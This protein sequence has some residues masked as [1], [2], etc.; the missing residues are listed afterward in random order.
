[1]AVKIVCGTHVGPGA[2]GAFNVTNSDLGGDTPDAVVM[3]CTHNTSD[4]ASIANWGLAIGLN[5]A[6]T[7]VANSQYAYANEEDGVARSD[8][9]NTGLIDSINFL[10]GE[11]TYGGGSGS[12]YVFRLTAY[13]ANGVTLDNLASVTWPANIQIHYMFI[14]GVDDSH[15]GAFTPTDTVDSSVDITAPGF[16]A[17]VVISV[18]GEDPYDGGKDTDGPVGI[19]FYAYDGSVYQSAAFFFSDDN[20]ANMTNGVGVYGSS[21]GRTPHTGNQG[22]YEY[23][24]HANGFSATTRNAFN[25]S[26]V[27]YLALKLPSGV[28][29]HAGTFQSPASATT[30]AVTGLGF[31]PQAVMLVQT[32]SA[33]SQGAN[34]V[35]NSGPGADGI[36][37]GAT[38]GPAAAKNTSA[39]IASEDGAAN[40]NCGQRSADDACVLLMQDDYA[41]GLDAVAVLDSFDIGGFTL[42]YT[43]CGSDCQSKYGIYLAI[44]EDGGAPPAA[45]PEAGIMVPYY[46]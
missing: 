11:D 12:P 24:S 32:K 3:W 42:D 28:S 38:S 22:R 9:I 6:A 40:G 37:I 17:D 41:G 10:V 21:G 13:I 25:V 45:E 43:T 4:G 16:R 15:A 1:M 31:K 30:K 18:L 5:S 34:G 36:S 7:G 33:T 26:D 29:A 14:S 27:L 19:G 23:A 39:G 44:E 35:D 2:S 46:M 8:S 20:S